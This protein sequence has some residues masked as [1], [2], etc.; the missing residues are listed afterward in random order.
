MHGQVSI[1]KAAKIMADA[2][3]PINL[4]VLSTYV[5]KHADVLKPQGSGR[6]SETL[7]DFELLSAHRA[8]NTRTE[9]FGNFGRADEATANARAQRKLRE[10]DL[11]ERQGELIIKTEAETGASEAVAAMKNAFALALNDT[12]DTLAAVTK[13]EARLIRPHLRTFEKQ[14]LKIFAKVMAGYLPEAAPK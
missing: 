9:H 14:G 13:V 10:L 8:A 5:K 2:G 11:A 6:G 12:A 7:V 4:S 3:H 1:T